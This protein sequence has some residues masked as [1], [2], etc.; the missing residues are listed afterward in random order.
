MTRKKPTR[1]PLLPTPEEARATASEL[2]DQRRALDTEIAGIEAALTWDAL[3]I[4]ER[5][6]D[7]L[8]TLRERAAPVADKKPRRLRVR[9]EDALD[10][11]KALLPKV[12]AANEAAAQAARSE[13]RKRA[14]TLKPEH[15]KVVERIADAL[16]KLATALDDEARLRDQVKSPNGLIPDTLPGMGFTGV[17]HAADH[18]SPVSEWF[19]R[20]R[21][22]GYITE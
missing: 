14:E 3:S 11:R 5:Q 15:A 10:E 1:T 2:A 7:R 20:A 12:F 6:S 9:L 4:D 17:G 22:A 8:T 16:E 18:N 21:R 13:N 19:R